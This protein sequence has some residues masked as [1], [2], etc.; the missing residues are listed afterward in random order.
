MEHEHAHEHALGGGPRHHDGH[1]HG[2]HEHR[3]DHRRRRRPFDYGELRLLVLG[4]IREAP[5]HGYE[6]MKGIEERMGGGYSPS[7]G[8]I[9]PTLAWLED[10]GYAAGDSEGSRRRYRITPEGEA[11]IAANQ[12][13]LA[14]LLARMGAPGGR[15]RT[16]EA[17]REAMGRLKRALGARLLQGPADPAEV[18]AIAAAI[19]GAAEAVEA[20]MA[21]AAAAAGLLRSAAEV[22]TPKAAGYLAQLC[23]HFAHKIP[24]SYEGSEGRIGFPRGECRLRAEGEALTMTVEAGDREAL[25]QLQ[26]VVARHLLRFAFREELAVEWRPA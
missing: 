19:E 1:H 17:V 2:H 3:H 9:Y 8:V 25:E 4:M 14:E 21:G 13:A 11:F 22:R 7:P 12:A 5:R 16:P 24:A 20:Q 23:K 6:L 18:A 10:M 15:R 26:D